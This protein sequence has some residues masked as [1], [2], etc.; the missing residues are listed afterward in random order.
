MQT[1]LNKF[2]QHPVW[3]QFILIT[4]TVGRYCK[5]QATN[6][7]IWSYSLTNSVL[8]VLLSA[9]T[10]HTWFTHMTLYAH[11]MPGCGIGPAIKTGPSSWRWNM[12]EQNRC[13]A[14]FK[15]LLNV[16][17]CIYR[18]LLQPFTH[19]FR[20]SQDH[21]MNTLTTQSVTCIQIKWSFL[22]N[23]QFSCLKLRSRRTH[24]LGTDYI[25]NAAVNLTKTPLQISPSSFVSESLQFSDISLVLL[26][27]WLSPD[28]TGLTLPLW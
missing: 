17:T 12:S 19:S 14:D 2:I 9:A 26:L 10:F 28:F 4:R 5:A 24:S 7:I 22:N 15:S 13:S 8:A 11:G 16:N 18:E 6:V 20:P 3:S 25:L 23:R 1:S 27:L 21:L